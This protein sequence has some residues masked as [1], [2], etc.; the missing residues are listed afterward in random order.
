MEKQKVIIDQLRSKLNMEIEDLSRLSTEDLKMIV[1]KAIGQIVNPAKVKEK[2]VDQLK[3]QI[4]DLE[5]FIQ[6]LQG[7]ILHMYSLN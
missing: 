7:K 6:F 2:L 4:T 3:T 1:D 5:R